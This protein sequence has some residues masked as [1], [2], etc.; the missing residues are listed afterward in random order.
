MSVTALIVDDSA[1]ARQIIGYHLRQAGCSIVGEA[2]NAADALKLFRELK[3]NIVSLDLMMPNKD[4]L[5]SL[6][7]VR[8]M[9]KE[10]PEIAVIVVS[11]IPFE[12]MRQSFIDEGVF[13][14]VVKPFNDFA[15]GTIRVKLRRTFPELAAIKPSA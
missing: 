10:A 12:K 5:D 7:L 1:A 9:K 4:N 8:A 15:L 14:Y 2:A 3:P 6:G 13:A 11:V